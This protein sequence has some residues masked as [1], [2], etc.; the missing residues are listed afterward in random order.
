M[1]EQQTEEG[2]I[3]SIGEQLAELK[4]SIMGEVRELIGSVKSGGSAQQ[5]AQKHEEAHLDRASNTAEGLESMVDAAIGKVLGAR[6]QAAAD[7]KH[8]AQHE[9]LEAAAAERPP[10][11]RTKRHKLM[12]WGEPSE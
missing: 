12:G 6:D 8:R 11:E 10:V 1:T 2:R 9:A 5:A 3:A 4:D 7:D